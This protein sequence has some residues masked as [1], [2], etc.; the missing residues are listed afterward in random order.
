MRAA[1][2][3]AVLFT[4]L[5]LASVAVSAPG[6]SDRAHSLTL[7]VIYDNYTFDPRL[8][9]APGFAVLIEGL[10]HNVLFDT[11]M[12]SSILLGN[13]TALG[14]EPRR[15]G[16]IVL[17][18]IHGDHVGGLFGLLPRTSA[19][20]VYLPES[21]PSEFKQRV[22]RAGADV[23]EVRGPTEIVDGAHST[24]ELGVAIKEQALVL[25]TDEG[26]IVITGCAHPGVVTI[27]S[28]ARTMLG[29]EIR[30]LVGGFHQSEMS[31]DRVREIIQ[32]LKAQGVKKV[33]PS[34]CSGDLSRQLFREEYGA[35]FVEVGVGRIIRLGSGSD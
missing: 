31:A 30:L 15:I 13:M 18:H 17:S 8:T 6:A 11:G 34:H 7:T 2:A 21:F 22:R 24:G 29:G 19:A 14:I 28:R 27:V 9:A 33:G 26:L 4:L 5:G 25:K 20:R 16:V 23:V 3:L 1:F 35:N 12:Q 32:R 10:G